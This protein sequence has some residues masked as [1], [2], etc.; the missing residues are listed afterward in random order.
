MNN[1]KLKIFSGIQPS[2]A[3]HIGNYVGAIKQ[4]VELQEKYDCI[5]SIV[6]YHATTVDYDP[7]KMP[8]QILDA[9]LD[10]LACGIDPEK[11]TIFVQSDR[12]EHTELSWILNCFIKVGELSQQEQYQQK[13]KIDEA[14]IKKFRQVLVMQKFIVRDKKSGQKYF[15]IPVDDEHEFNNF[16]KSMVVGLEKKANAGLLY[17]PVLMTADILIYKANK[18]PVGEDQIQHIELARKIARRFN[19]KFNQTFP[20]P[21][22]MI[23]KGARILG[24]NGKGKMAKS[25]PPATYIALTDTPEVI[26]EKV[27]S[28]VTDKGTEPEISPGSQNLFTL[29]E[30]FAGPDVAKKFIEQR[31]N[32]TIKYSELKPVLAEAIIKELEPI[33]KKRSELAKEPERVKKILTE[34]AEKLKPQAQKTISEVK[35]KM[36]LKY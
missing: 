14:F 6:D 4:F 2:G 31:K 15:R 13:A 19:K 12:P 11:A 3:I 34:G 8:Q 10:Y 1:K 23:R 29:L 36:G 35:E 17:Y 16:L 21:D 9:A 32:K 33:Q 5:Y 26:R 22:A 24:L 18:V 30:I 27:A 20:E 25:N 7:K 28:S